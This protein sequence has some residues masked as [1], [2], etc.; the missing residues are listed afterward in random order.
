MDIA[1]VR[2]VS[3]SRSRSVATMVGRRLAPK[4]AGAAPGLTETFVREAL[5]RA[6]QGVGPLPGAAAAAEAQLRDQP[7]LMARPILT[8]GTTYTLRWDDAAQAVWLA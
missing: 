4:V 1:L 5:D 7:A 6:I 2:S 3:L 8:D